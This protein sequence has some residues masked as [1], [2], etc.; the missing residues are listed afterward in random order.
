MNAVAEG[1]RLLSRMPGIRSLR[2]G[3]RV[4]HELTIGLFVSTAVPYYVADKGEIVGVYGH[5]REAAMFHW[6]RLFDELS[7]PPH[8]TPG[9]RIVEDL[10]TP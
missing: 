2:I 6:A 10:V 7:T 3:H 4:D 8:W 5:D 1:V 9:C